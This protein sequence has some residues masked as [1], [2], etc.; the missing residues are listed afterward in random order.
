M[1][2]PVK[3]NARARARACAV[4]AG[5]LYVQTTAL[6]RR[7]LS[8]G[9][10]AGGIHLDPNHNFQR[11]R[12]WHSNK[13]PRAIPA[14][15]ARSR[16]SFLLPRREINFRDRRRR[17]THCRGKSCRANCGRLLRRLESSPSSS[18]SLLLHIPRRRGVR[19]R[20]GRGNLG[21]TR[22]RRPKAGG[23]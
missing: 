4:T 10:S 8:S 11:N 18:L 5:T 22:R 16:S 6:F 7:F 23:M 21:R 15:A 3:R 20:S 17:S 1:Y 9:L 12:S 13:F 14:A 2:P 19:S